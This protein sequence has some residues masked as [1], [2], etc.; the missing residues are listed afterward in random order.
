MDVLEDVGPDDRMQVSL[1]EVK[2][3]VD[4]FVVFCLEDAEETD[5]VGVS[6]QLLQEN[7]LTLNQ[8]TYL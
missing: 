1:H 8:L 3:Q 2:H 4:V 5:N 7:H 6:V